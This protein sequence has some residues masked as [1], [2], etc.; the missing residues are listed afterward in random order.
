M[1][2]YFERSWDSWRIE[3]LQIVRNSLTNWYKL[4]NKSFTH[5]NASY[6]IYMHR[7]HRHVG[8]ELCMANSFK[9]QLDF[10][11]VFNNKQ[12]RAHTRSALTTIFFVFFLCIW[13]KTK[14]PHFH[15]IFKHFIQSSLT[16]TPFNAFVW[17]I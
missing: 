1:P 10:F 3:Q 8:I 12:L 6:A 11:L 16:W 7:Y 5:I 14:V 9:V 4:H 17:R 13:I 2:I 15:A